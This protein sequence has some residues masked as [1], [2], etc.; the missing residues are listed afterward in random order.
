MGVWELIAGLVFS[1][2]GFVAFVYGRKMGQYRP[3]LIGVLLMGYP[4]FTPD[5]LWLC[6]IGAVLTLALFIWKE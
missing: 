4:Y 1:G 3:A 2:I 5:L 6:G